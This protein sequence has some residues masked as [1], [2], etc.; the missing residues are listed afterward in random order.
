MSL[1]AVAT[2]QRIIALTHPCVSADQC[3][4]SRYYFPAGLAPGKHA[5]VGMTVNV[6][7][8]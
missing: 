7:E 1:R 3:S 5:Y 8:E 4:A 2:Q 6:G